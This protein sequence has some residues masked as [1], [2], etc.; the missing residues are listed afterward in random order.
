MPVMFLLLEYQLCP[1][2]LSWPTRKQTCVCVHLNTHA[3]VCVYVDIHIQFQLS[4]ER[5][6]SNDI[7][8][9][10]TSPPYLYTSIPIHHCSL[11]FSLSKYIYIYT[12][13]LTHYKHITYTYM[14]IQTYIWSHTDVSG[15]IISTTGFILAF[16]HSIFHFFNY[17]KPDSHHKL[18]IYNCGI[19][20]VLFKKYFATWRSWINFLYCLLKSLLFFHT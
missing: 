8:D 11:P 15:L 19:F 17:E 10:H 6:K 5:F 20:G 9:M 1:G 18:F 2:P 12:N 3:Y 16:L 4:I 14:D 13:R 7:Q